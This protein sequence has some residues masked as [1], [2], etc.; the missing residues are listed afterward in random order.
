MNRASVVIAALGLALASGWGC[1]GA[2]VGGHELATYEAPDSPPVPLP[3]GPTFFIP[4]EEMTWDISLHG[5][6]GA[7]ASLALGQPGVVDGHNAVVVRSRTRTSGVLSMV[8]EVRDE[9]T[10]WVD[11]ETGAPIKHEASLK[12]GDK[13]S[14][15]QTEFTPRGYHLRY[16][17]HGR[18]GV[19]HYIQAIPDGI[20][21]DGLSIIGALR[22]WEPAD[23]ARAYFYVLSGRRLWRNDIAFSKRETLKTAFGVVPTLRF[24][25]SGQRL[26]GRLRVVTSKPPR[27]YTV[28]I[29][30]DANRLPV[31]VEAHTEYGNVR[32]EM[33]HYDRPERRVVSR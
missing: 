19:M 24:E 10:S 5:I 12:F 25:G 27:T 20:A 32:V 18:P 31:L 13:E 8:K 4:G 11:L 1:G 7:Q 23:G 3:S 26:D 33:I 28:W 9:V 2:N 14:E 16:Q 30:D 6:V 17:R 21:H 29:T 15:V 22:A